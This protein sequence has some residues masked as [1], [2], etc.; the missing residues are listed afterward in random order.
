MVCIPT[1]GYHTSI[2]LFTTLIILSTLVLKKS[3]YWRCGET[4]LTRGLLFCTSSLFL[5]HL[6]LTTWERQERMDYPG[7]QGSQHTGR[8]KTFTANACKRTAKAATGPRLLSD[9]LVVPSSDCH[10]SHPLPTPFSARSLHAHDKSRTW[11]R[12]QKTETPTETSLRALRLHGSC[13]SSRDTCIAVAFFHC[14]VSYSSLASKGQKEQGTTKAAGVTVWHRYASPPGNYPAPANPGG[15]HHS[16]WIFEDTEPQAAS[17][18]PRP[19]TIRAEKVLKDL[20]WKVEVQ[21]MMSQSPPLMG[22]TQA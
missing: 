17:F 15:R 16:T 20:I 8:R 2:V 22:R 6:I 18:P 14:S 4:G 19:I 1:G 12:N 21:G 5:T 9:V 3:S 7:Q 10:V 13:S 11:N